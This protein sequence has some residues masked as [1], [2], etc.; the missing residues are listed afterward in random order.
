[1]APLFYLTYF[2]YFRVMKY[3]MIQFGSNIDIQV[4]Y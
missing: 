4:K 2:Q 1:M 3:L